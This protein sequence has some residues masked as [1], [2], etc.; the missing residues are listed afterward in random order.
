LAIAFPEHGDAP[1]GRRVLRGVIEKVRGDLLEAVDV[2]MHPQRLRTQGYFKLVASPIDEWTHRLYCTLYDVSQVHA[3]AVEPDSSRCN[4][5]DVQQ[6]VDHAAHA[7][8]LSFD[9]A[10]SQ[11]L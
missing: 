7:A 9:D 3:L 10:R 1:A 8:G 2:R 5:G 6:L 4:S 11:L